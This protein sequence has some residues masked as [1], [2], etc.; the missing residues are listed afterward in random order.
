MAY[1]GIL[2]GPKE[3]QLV[4]LVG[5]NYFGITPAHLISCF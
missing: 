4:D 3:S 2:K 1:I 5:H